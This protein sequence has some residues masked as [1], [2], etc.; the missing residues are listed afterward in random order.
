MDEQPKR[1]VG[2]PTHRQPRAEAPSG[3][4]RRELI[5]AVAG[6]LF[7]E[8]GYSRTSMRDIATA[9]GLLSGSLYYYF[10]SKEELF[11][12]V[13]GTGM[14]I[15][16]RAAEAALAGG[17][18]PWDRLARLAAAHCRAVL[19]NQGFMIMV[20]PQFQEELG[21]CRPELVRQRDA[22]EQLVGAAIADLD[23]RPPLD[24]V[25]FRLQ[26]LGALNWSQTWFRPGGPHS[27]EEIGRHLVAML[28]PR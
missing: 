12:E 19:E 4:D 17:G 3:L 14:A 24:P 9:A 1:R 21:S 27:P 22:Y 6:S 13:H 16:T 7:V 5:V 2:R 10:P 25:L 20:F 26:F 28:R 23:L 15:L 18:D 8:R 11:V